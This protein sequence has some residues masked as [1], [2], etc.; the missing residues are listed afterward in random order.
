MA[1]K[2]RQREIV[3]VSFSMPDGTNLVHPALVVSSNELQEVEDG[4][5][6]VLLISSKNHHPEYTIKIEN[7]WLSKPMSKQSYFIT[8][9]MGMYNV[10]E[11][12]AQRNC[13]VKE[14]YFDRIIDK[15]VDTI[16]G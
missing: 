15:I 9:I 13:F 16:F 4:M 8:H 11:V 1:M 10:D 3:E 6:Y 7:E 2:V 14:K 12:I 5:I